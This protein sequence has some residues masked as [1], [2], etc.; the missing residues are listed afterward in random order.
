MKKDR[1]NLV[2]NL[3]L[4]LAPTV[5]FMLALFFNPTKTC[6]VIGWLSSVVLALGFIAVKED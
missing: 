4:V 6:N 5:G 2:L 1:L 3:V